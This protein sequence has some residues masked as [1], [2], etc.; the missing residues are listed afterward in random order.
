MKHRYRGLKLNKT[1][2]E[3]KRGKS[4]FE[5]KNSSDDNYVR[6]DEALFLSGLARSR[7]HGADLVKRGLVKFNQRTILRPSKTIPKDNLEALSL[8][9]GAVSSAVSRAGE[10]LAGAAQAFGFD[11]KDKTVLDVGSSTGGFTQYALNKGA[12]KVIAVEVG[13]N[14]MAPEIRA[15]SKVELH[16]KTDI[17]DFKTQQKIDVIVMDVSFISLTK[18]L[19]SLLNLIKEAGSHP[20]IIAMAKPQFEGQP[21]DLNAGVIKN[22]AIRRRI[23][24]NLE[25]WLKLNNFVITKK[26][27]SSLSGKKGNQERFYWLSIGDK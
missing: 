14:Q 13:T 27:D 1:H 5:Q 25:D 22:S 23:L 7:S 15:D 6:A 10:K 3:K 24:K 19:P 21:G 26:Q 2:G 20:D 8:S 17:R 11:F 18:I 12:K 9:E 4:A 16:E